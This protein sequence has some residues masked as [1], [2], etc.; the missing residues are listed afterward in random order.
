VKG[1]EGRWRVQ[2]FRSGLGTLSLGMRL[3]LS[4]M[5]GGMLRWPSQ[6]VKARVLWEDADQTSLMG[7]VCCLYAI[8]KEVS[9]GRMS[10]EVANQRTGIVADCGYAVARV[11]VNSTPSNEVISLILNTGAFNYLVNCGSLPRL[12][13]LA[14]AFDAVHQVKAFYS[15]L[16]ARYW[17]YDKAASKGV[18]RKTVVFQMTAFSQ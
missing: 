17:V 4:M 15:T 9:H 12:T 8:L 5:G 13:N 10:F 3:M 6:G 1:L 7:E 18:M 11:W 2:R 16:N 14:W